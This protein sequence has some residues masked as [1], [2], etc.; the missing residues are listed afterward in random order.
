MTGKREGSR[1]WPAAMAAVTLLS[2]AVGCTQAARVD[3]AANSATGTMPSRGI[4]ISADSLAAVIGR[5]ENGAAPPRLVILYV[6]RAG[7]A[8]DTTRIPGARDL[9]MD[10]LVVERDGLP[11]ELPPVSALDS[12]FESVG[13]TDDARIVLY[14]DPLAAA[15]AFFTLDV[16]GHGGHTAV[17]DG[18][19]QAWLA[20]G[21]PVAPGPSTG[22][23][24]VTGRFNPHLAREQVVDASWV[25]AHA[26]NP[27]VALI[28]ARPPEE[29]RGERAG[30]GVARPGH[31]PGAASLYWKR[32]LVSEAFPRLKDADSLR[33]LF[34]EAGAA[35]GD[36]VVTYCRTG[37]QSSHA[38]FVAR[39]LG[40]A[41]RMYDASFIDWSRQS[42]RPVVRGP[43]PT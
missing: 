38:Y 7:T 19:M 14:G 11:N 39:Y 36:T 40:F 22:R 12:V 35:P 37:V 43:A 8:A 10:A 31:I 28:D 4:L 32:T 6:A 27:R 17:L 1:R 41:V 21:G 15:R 2:G 20:R 25:A 23:T 33:A 3:G 16:L 26:G 42:A 24:V 34:A 18:G 30:E 9:P 29:Y 5:E 13:V